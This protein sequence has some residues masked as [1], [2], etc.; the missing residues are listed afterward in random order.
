MFDPLDH[1][2]IPVDHHGRHW[3]ELELEVDSRATDPSTLRRIS[4]VAA[5]EAKA[6]HFDRNFANRVQD[7]DARR[8][9]GS[10]GAA[11]AQRRQHIAGVRPSPHNTA[12]DA[13]DRERA[14]FEMAGWAARNEPDPDRSSQ[15]RQLAWQ[16]LERLR[17]YADSGD[18]AHLRWA[19]QMADEVDRSW[20]PL[21]ATPAR[22]RTPSP[23]AIQP[24]SLLH[25][26]MVRAAGRPEGWE[27]LV[28]QESAGCYL[29]YAFMAEEDDRRLRPMWELH[30]QMQL[31]HLQTASALLRRYAGRDAHEVI[32][33]GLPE[34]ATLRTDRSPA[35]IHNPARHEHARSA[36]RRR[37]RTRP[38]RE[39]DVLELL[40]EH[41]ART[42]RLFDSAARSTGDDARMAFGELAR[43]IAM[44]EIVEERIV[45][46]LIRRLRPDHHLADRLLDEESQISEAL[47][48]AVRT[49]AHGHLDDAIDGLPDLVAPHS[50]GEEH[51]EFPQIGRAHV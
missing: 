9:V 12:E 27:A 14:A 29:Y 33:E 46:P 45:H 48:D 20:P 41:H 19:D 2:G 3:H 36:R 18:R 31:A 1:P 28:V 11:T 38:D 40:T 32:G 4:M 35:P 34:P 43:L 49:A 7:V 47:A 25:D 5:V 10:L 26:W 16:H 22:G 23:P 42:S 8:S 15:Y 21:P 51:D 37:R 17:R 13:I 50:R 39:Q 6:E 30:L 24:L 44:H